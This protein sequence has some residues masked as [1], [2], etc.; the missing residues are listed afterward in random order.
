MTAYNPPSFIVT[1]YNPSFFNSSDSGSGLTQAQANALYLQKTTPDTA[2]ALESFNAGI[3]TNTIDSL[4]NTGTISIG[5][6]RNE[7]A[8]TLGKT[9]YSTTI[10][11]NTLTPFKVSNIDV[12]GTIPSAMTIGGTNTN[13]LNLGTLN[14]TQVNIGSASL[15]ASNININGY[16]YAGYSTFIGYDLMNNSIID[17][18]SS[19]NTINIAPTN[20]TGVVIGSSSTIPTILID[21]ASTLNTD[22][23]P[24]IAIGTS[25]SNKTIKIN[26]SSASTHISGLDVT[27]SGLNN[28]TGGSGLL[29]IGN[30]QT[31]GVMNIGNNASRS[32]AINIGQYCTGQ[33]NIGGNATAAGGTIN[34]GSALQ[35]VTITGGLTSPS[36]INAAGGI[37]TGTI[38]S[39]SLPLNLG[40]S[41]STSINIGHGTTEPVTIYGLVNAP[42]SIT[43]PSVDTSS[44]STLS[45]GTS[46]ATGITLGKTGVAVTI[47]GTLSLTGLATETGGIK[48][49]SIQAL[50]NTDAISLYT[51]DTSTISVGSATSTINLVGA[52]TAPTVTY[53][54]NST[55]IST[56]AYT[57]AAFT[58]FKAASNTFTAT[59]I[60]P[61]I[62][63][64]S[65]TLNI[66]FYIQYVNNI[67]FGA[68]AANTLVS[69]VVSYTT[70]GLTNYSTS[71]FTA[72][73]SNSSSASNGPRVNFTIAA[74]S[75]SSLTITASNP[76]ST[77]TSACAYSI[78]L[79]GY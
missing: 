69:S 58:A 78:I 13:Q 28:I 79:F 45:I 17:T 1:I 72:L 68:V 12:D 51:L 56:T 38:E 71:L 60:I 30:L 74:Q 18:I 3:Y 41:T 62:Q 29:N 70:L 54:N 67:A 40:A 5:T 50:T 10:K 57:T 75:T 25:S 23:N 20:A 55:S 32:A 53:P 47:P 39:P 35:P 33:I 19:G 4:T 61:S 66:P 8:L 63:F 7:T 65:G 46:S 16:V 24:A 6:V 64:S 59:Q 48:T 52:S 37:N 22:A 31:S 43:T 73:I 34:I 76:T 2:T 77:A 49:D 9:T 15:A 14:S 26:N 44:A 36:L 21:T 42:T 11:S 27:G